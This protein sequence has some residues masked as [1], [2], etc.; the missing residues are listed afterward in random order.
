MADGIDEAARRANKLI[1]LRLCSFFITDGLLE[2]P[3]NPG[4]RKRHTKNN[5]P[6]S[7]LQFTAHPKSCGN[8]EAAIASRDQDLSNGPT[9]LKIIDQLVLT[10]NEF[11]LKERIPSQTFRWPDE[12]FVCAQCNQLFWR[13][14]HWQTIRSEIDGVSS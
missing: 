4:S 2:E 1:I 11:H 12:Y 14:T 13:G 8:I 6:K 9:K 7:T 3:K 10:F 5:L